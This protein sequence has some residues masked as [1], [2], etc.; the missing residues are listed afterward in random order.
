[1]SGGRVS[2]KGTQPWKT[3]RTFY[4]LALEGKN[5]YPTGGPDSSPMVQPPRYVNESGASVE[6][7]EDGQM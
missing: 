4:V 7:Q 1:M 3:P 6:T 5:R 2:G